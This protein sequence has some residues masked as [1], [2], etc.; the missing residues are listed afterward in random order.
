MTI[1]MLVSIP[2]E[3][4]DGN[5]VCADSYADNWRDRFM[6]YYGSFNFTYVV[7]DGTVNDKIETPWYALEYEGYDIDGIKEAMMMAHNF[8]YSEESSYLNQEGDDE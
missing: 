8:A 5:Q 3:D 7:D 2:S 1:E 6:E 4:F